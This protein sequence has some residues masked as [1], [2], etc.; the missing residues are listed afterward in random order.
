GPAGSRTPD[1]GGCWPGGPAPPTR[2]AG[3]AAGCCCWPTPTRAPASWRWPHS[4]SPP[5][6]EGTC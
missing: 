1:R 3:P 6:L 4:T 2:P 5:T